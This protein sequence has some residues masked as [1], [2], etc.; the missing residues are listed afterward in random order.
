MHLVHHLY[1]R[2]PIVPSAPF[3]TNSPGLSFASHHLQIHFTISHVFI[4]GIRESST[5][6]INNW[7]YHRRGIHFRFIAN[8]VATL[9]PFV[10]W[11]IPV[12]LL[13]AIQPKSPLTLSST[14]ITRVGLP[15]GFG[16]CLAAWPPQEPVHESKSYSIKPFTVPLLSLLTV[17]SPA[18]R[19]L[20]STV[21]SGC[22]YL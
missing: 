15:L 10:A 4:Q 2:T 20:P 18:L 6:L 17:T 12:A 14:A 13:F 9:L 11:P 22:T 21:P 5:C 7:G 1:P 3:N 16:L 19:S 8:Q